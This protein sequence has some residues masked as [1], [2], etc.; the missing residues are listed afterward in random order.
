MNNTEPLTPLRQHC[1]LEVHPVI[2]N[3]SLVRSHGG[4]A[5]ISAATKVKSSQLLLIR[6]T[7]SWAALTVTAWFA[8]QLGAWLCEHSSV[9]HNSMQV[10]ALLWSGPPI[11]YLKI[12]F[13]RILICNRTEV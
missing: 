1:I 10:E 11:K 8:A 2:T 13:I 4:T 5:I 9:L 7:W 12:Y 3:E 6:D